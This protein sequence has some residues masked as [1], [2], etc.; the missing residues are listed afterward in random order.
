MKHHFLDLSQD[1]K[2]DY[3][4]SALKRAN[5][6]IAFGD[7]MPGVAATVWRGRLVT[8]RKQ[9]PE[10]AVVISGEFNIQHVPEPAMTVEARSQKIYLHDLNSCVMSDK[11]GHFLYPYSVHMPHEKWLKE[12]NPGDKVWVLDSEFEHTEI[13]LTD[14]MFDDHMYVIVRFATST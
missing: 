7:R 4:F 3:V 10:N 8:P 6:T 2:Y 1:E 9:L 14:K 11:E 13:T 12:Q 5:P